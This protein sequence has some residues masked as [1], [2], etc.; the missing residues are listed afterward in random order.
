MSTGGFT[1]PIDSADDFGE[2]VT[3]IGDLDGDGIEDVVIGERANDS[4]GT[5]RGALYVLLMNANGTVKSEQRISDLVGN[6]GGTLD[7]F[8]V[9]GGCAENVGDLNDDNV[10]DLAVCAASDDDGGTDRGAVWI[11]F[12][13]TDG[14][15]ASYDKISDTSGNLTTSLDNSDKF[16]TS[17]AVI[18]DLNGDGVD[19][20]AVGAALDDDSGSSQSAERGAVYIL[21]MNANGTIASEAKISGSTT[22]FT[23]LLDDGDRFGAA[24]DA[25]GDLDNDGIS[26]IVV[27]AWNDDD[28]GTDRG[29]QYVIYLTAA[30]GVKRYQKISDTQGNFTGVLDDTDTMGFQVTAEDFDGDG[31]KEIISG[32]YQDDD[33]GSGRG[34]LWVM[35]LQ[36]ISPAHF[37]EGKFPKQTSLLINEG[38][39][40]TPT[41]E[42][43]LSLFGQYVEDVVISNDQLFVE[44][45]WELF[46]DSYPMQK[47]WNLLPFDGPQT[48][49]AVFQSSS[50]NRS[51]LQTQT[52]ILDQAGGCADYQ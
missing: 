35:F 47:S 41:R 46:K 34:A 19:E 29:A 18:P 32:A 16:G 14:T 11:L 28:G 26:E 40:C 52:I 9:F 33:G 22:N 6:F 1:G 8:D 2:A 44:S 42:V 25:L 31:F 45:E 48:V 43:T 38:A 50:N 27:G 37:K 36:L 10:N 24:I 30:G 3:G 5:D 17:V 13:N 20:W 4:G 51:G 21:Y 15:V 12:M 7:N 39:V 49:Y 23:G